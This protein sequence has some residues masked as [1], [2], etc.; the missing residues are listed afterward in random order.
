MDLPSTDTLMNTLHW[1]QR[2]V[3][4]PTEKN[5]NTQLGV[6]FEEVAEMVLELGPASA[7]TA[8]LLD[9]CHNAL[10]KLAKHLKT[11]GNAVVI[12]TDCRHNFL[13]AICDQIVTGVGSAYMV[14]MSAPTALK[15]VN[16][17]NFS[18]F[19]GD[20]N[21]IFDENMKVTKGPNYIKPDL[22]PYT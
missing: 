15:E 1:F 6:H 19:D 8:R 21:P 3:P 9:E 22:T 11:N 17:G 14:G 12:P 4:N 16:R 18:K 13:D 10:S 7:E 20:G 2:A 5:L